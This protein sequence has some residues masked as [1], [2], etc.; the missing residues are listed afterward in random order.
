MARKPGRRNA[1]SGQF[2]AIPRAMLECAA[3]R[4]LSL[5]GRRTLDRLE[6][7]HMSH[8]GCEKGKL[9]TTY[10]PA[11]DAGKNDASG[12]HEYLRIATDAEA[13]AIAKA[14]RQNADVRN[15][16]R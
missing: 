13:D 15:V 12:T 1:I 9:P 2:A 16:E 5:A 11:W 3:R 14:A 8:G 6:V 10:F 4:A 7:E